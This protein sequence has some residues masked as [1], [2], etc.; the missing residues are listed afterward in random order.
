MMR[1]LRQIGL[2][3]L[4][5][6]AAVVIRLGLFPRTGTDTTG[7]GPTMLRVATYNINYG[8]ERLD[9]VVDAVRESNADVVAFQEVT[10]ES[11]AY[12]REHLGADYPHVAFEDR[13]GPRPAQGF[14]LLSKWPIAKTEHLPPEHGRFGLQIVD[15][16]LGERIV[17]VVNVH[18]QPIRVFEARGPLD[19]FKAYRET[20]T[21]H[22]AEI[23]WLFEA[24]DAKSGLDAGRP[25]IILGDFNSLSAFVAPTFLREH[26]FADSFAAVTDDADQHPSW[27]WPTR[28]GAIRARIDY[29]WHGAAFE[30]VESR[31]IRNDSSD[32][33]LVVSELRLKAEAK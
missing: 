23:A 26:G 22:A 3:I 21:I 20:E 17:R 27:E 5:A 1:R 24:I 29:I 31:I 25:T 4:V 14:G 32:H 10:D 15:V 13:P 9:L 28:A 11:E 6:A 2:L 7:G 16:Q 19:F 33:F 18:L 8:N 12:L 30:T